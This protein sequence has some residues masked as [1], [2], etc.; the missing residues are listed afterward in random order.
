MQNYMPLPYCSGVQPP[1]NSNT[2]MNSHHQ[3]EMRNLQQQ[4]KNLQQQKKS[5]LSPSA[6]S[7]SSRSVIRSTSLANSGKNPIYWPYHQISSSKSY[8]SS[9]ILDSGAI[10]HMTLIFFFEKKKEGAIDH[11]TLMSHNVVLYKPCI[12]GKNI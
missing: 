10:D 11:M 7:T 3:Q 5:L 12:T 1:T 2:Q 9:W 4:I 6:A 8:Q